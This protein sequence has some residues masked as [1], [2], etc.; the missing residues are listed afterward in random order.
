M[1][2]DQV[3]RLNRAYRIEETEHWS[4]LRRSG[5]THKLHLGGVG[6]CCST[7]IEFANGGS[8]D[9]EWLDALGKHWVA[10]GESPVSACRKSTAVLL[11]EVA[12]AVEANQQ[13]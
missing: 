8:S 5:A 12:N 13:G 6:R 10:T 9:V 3:T 2:G 1:A 4:T 7:N 11:Q